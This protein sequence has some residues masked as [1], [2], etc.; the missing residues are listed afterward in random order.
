MLCSYDD[1]GVFTINDETMEDERES[2]P[3]L[4]TMEVVDFGGFDV[5]RESCQ[6]ER[7]VDDT[8]ETVSVSDASVEASINSG[9]AI[10]ESEANELKDELDLMVEKLESKSYTMI[11][12]QI[13]RGYV[14]DDEEENKEKEEI[15]ISSASTKSE[16]IR[17][18]KQ[19]SNADDNDVSVSSYIGSLKSAKEM[20]DAIQLTV[21]EENSVASKGH[22]SRISSS[23]NSSCLHGV[24]FVKTDESSVL[25]EEE[26]SQSLLGE[27]NE[28][29][30]SDG[31]SD[32]F[33][34]D[35][36]L[37]VVLEIDTAKD[38]GAQI[39]PIEDVSVLTPELPMKAPVP[40]MAFSVDA[41]SQS[42]SFL[43][44][45]SPLA[46][47]PT[48]HGDEILI[49]NHSSMVDSKASEEVSHVISIDLEPKFMRNMASSDKQVNS[50]AVAPALASIGSEDSTSSRASSDLWSGLEVHQFDDEVFNK[51]E[52][53]FGEKEEDGSVFMSR[54]DWKP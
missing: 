53:I 46:V 2:Y 4:T 52:E 29:D 49:S 5:V 17:S 8:T 47:T 21:T 32:E 45:Q 36:T 54:D 38:Q 26:S 39:S 7:E 42:R 14:R 9:A 48:K 1:H 19:L 23:S 10:V 22:H 40:S 33:Q 41:A 31:G 18:A 11:Y 44:S 37:N 15:S 20:N 50:L 3:A 27:A 35:V 34:G 6:E 51:A 30:S 13:C 43:V 24:Y 28:I 12:E 16:S 25:I